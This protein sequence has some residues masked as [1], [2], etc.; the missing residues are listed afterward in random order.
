M[1]FFCG[2]SSFAPICG[3]QHG[4]T[5][6]A[7]RDEG[8]GFAPNQLYVASRPRVFTAVVVVVIFY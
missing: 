1:F 6:D 5:D 7:R 8:F 2:L 3:A 4:E